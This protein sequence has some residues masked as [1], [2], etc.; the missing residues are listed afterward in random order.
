[1]N[2]EGVFSKIKD[3]IK[4][5][6]AGDKKAWGWKN[7]AAHALIPGYTL[8][9]GGFPGQAKEVPKMVGGATTRSQSKSNKPNLKLH[10]KIELKATPWAHIG[11]LGAF[12]TKKIKEGTVLGVYD[13]E[14]IDHPA[15]LND[16]KYDDNDYIYESRDGTYIRDGSDDNHPN[17]TW[18]KYINDPRGTGLDSNLRFNEIFDWESIGGK[19]RRYT[20]TVEVIAKTDIPKGAELFIDYGETFWKKKTKRSKKKKT[21]EKKKK[22]AEKKKRPEK[23]KKLLPF[24]KT[25][26][27]D[28]TAELIA[29]ADKLDDATFDA[30]NAFIVEIEEKTYQFATEWAQRQWEIAGS[31]PERVEEFVRAAKR[32]FFQG[33]EK[34]VMERFPLPDAAPDFGDDPPDQGGD[35]DDTVDFTVDDKKASPPPR[36]R[37]TPPS[38]ASPPPKRKRLLPKKW[39]VKKLNQRDKTGWMWQRSD[40][41]WVRCVRRYT[42]KTGVSYPVCWEE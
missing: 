10:A 37:K 15:G 42:R 18:T 28:Y 11:G 19:S 33:L 31:P 23:K 7:L 4:S 39:R 17:T 26:P 1:M 13:G 21:P 38:K 36:K 40:G 30:V 14:K 34:E 9:V 22:T 6:M 35:D 41:K 16:P 5:N 8:L 32:V 25:F 2:G 29:H 27:P 20:K 24:P 3:H 12:A